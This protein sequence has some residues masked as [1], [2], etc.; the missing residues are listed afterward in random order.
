MRALILVLFFS[1]NVSAQQGLVGQYLKLLPSTL[2]VT[3]NAGDLRVQTGSDVLNLCSATN[4]WSGFGVSSTAPMTTLGD[5]IY[6][7]STP[8]PA[9]L[10]GQT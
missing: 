1:L 5:M 7:N 3:C 9:R 6:E 2:P 8:V 4:T 10:A